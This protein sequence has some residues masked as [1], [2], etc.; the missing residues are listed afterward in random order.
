MNLYGYINDNIDRIRRET[1]LGL[2][3]TSNLRHWE[4]YGR[5]DAHKKMGCGK[6]DAVLNT[7]GDMRVSERVIFKIIKKMEQQV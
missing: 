2:M 6:C 4:I 5:Y 7:S 1:R 3:P